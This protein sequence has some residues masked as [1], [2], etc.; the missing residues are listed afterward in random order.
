LHDVGSNPMA[1]TTGIGLEQLVCLAQSDSLMIP[2]RFRR[3]D[4]TGGIR[5]GKQ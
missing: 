3:V 2:C 4:S 5:A 1:K